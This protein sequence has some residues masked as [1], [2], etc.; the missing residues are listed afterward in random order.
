MSDPDLIVLALK[1]VYI[2]KLIFQRVLVIVMI[3]GIIVHENKIGYLV[4]LYLKDVGD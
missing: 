4:H 1:D 2:G 3:I